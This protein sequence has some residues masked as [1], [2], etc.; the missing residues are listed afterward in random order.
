MDMKDKKI[1]LIITGSIAAY[2]SAILTRLLVKSGA[3]VRI[4]MTPAAKEFVT[5]LTMSTLSQNEVLIDMMH[6]NQ[7]NSHVDL[8]IWADLLLVAPA[9]ANSLAKMA[10]G[11][12]DNLA[13][14]TYLSAK[15][16]VMIAP[17]M[18]LDMWQHP[19]TKK[20]IAKLKD[21]SH[22]IIPVGSG[23][24]ASG[25]KGEGRM[26]E[27]EEIVEF[28]NDFFSKKKA[29]QDLI[30]KKVLITAGPTYES[31][32]PVRF[33]GNHSSGKMGLAIAQ[34][35]SERGAEVTMVIGPSNLQIPDEIHCIRVVSA[36][37][38]AEK[39][40]L[41]S[42]A[43]DII[44][45]AAAVADYTPAHPSEIKIKK[46]EGPLS[47]ELERTKDIAKQIGQEKRSDQFLVGFAL[48]TND[49][50]Q[51]ARTKLKKKNFDMIVLNSLQD[52]GAGF[53]HDTNKISIISKDNK[54]EDFELKSKKAVARDIIDH[55]I[56]LI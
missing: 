50:V 37:E 6:E 9:T 40:L 4:V 49:A 7:W 2:K 15:C 32:D 44:I 1:L 47:I 36:A 33:I 55:V 23:E 29:N 24:L 56:N 10:I 30:A 51:N 38:M 26:A 8:G 35:C 16:P 5:P 45:L 11:L 42:P 25:L 12:A 17:A 53:K 34:E 14:T 3:E 31:I 43:S 46:K 52:A 21:Y 41:H 28:V 13:M 22:E 19:T 27:P 48:E 39:C 18:D 20:N 54:M